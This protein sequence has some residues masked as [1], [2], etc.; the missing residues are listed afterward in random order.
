MMYTYYKSHFRGRSK[1][2]NEKEL[3]VQVHVG[4]QCVYTVSHETGLMYY[5]GH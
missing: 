4:L 2:T 1:Y 3:T 5:C